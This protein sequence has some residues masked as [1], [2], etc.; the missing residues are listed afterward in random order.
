M[1]QAPLK[2]P[3]TYQWVVPII[4]QSVEKNPGIQYEALRGLIRPYAKEYAITPSL[5]QDAREAAKKVI[6][7]IA[8]DNV[9][10]A[11]GVLAAMRELGH[12]A[13]LVYTSRDETLAA[14]N[15]IVIYEEI[16]RRKIKNE[17]PFDGIADRMAFWKKWKEDNALW[18]IN[19]LGIKGGPAEN[20][21]LSGILVATSASKSIFDTTQEV[22]QADGAHTSFGKYTLFSAYSTT[23]NANMSSV[24][25]GI[26]FGNE[27]IKNWTL[28]WKFVARIHPTINRPVVTLL[29]D[30]DKGSITSV[31]KVIPLAHNFHCSYHRRQ[32]ILSKCGGG[33]SGTKPL[34]ALWLYNMLSNC[35]NLQQLETYANR[36]LHQLFP[37]DSHYLTKI[38][39]NKQYAAARCAMAP[40]IQMYGQSASSG[41][42]SMN[43]ANKPL[44]REKTAVDPLNAAILLLQLE[45]GRFNKWKKIAWA[46]D[47]PLTPKGMDLMKDAFNDVN[48][49]EYKL[50]MQQNSSSQTYNVL[51][52]KNTNGAREFL[53]ALPKVALKGSH[54]G[55]CTCG[56]PAKEG[57]PCKHMVVIVKSSVIAGLTRTG[58]MPHFWSA[59][60]WRDQYPLDVECNTDISMANVKLVAHRHG[61][62]RYCPDWTAGGK[63]GRPKKTDKVMT[64]MDHIKVA[65]NKKRKRT[66]K[67]FCKICEKWNHTT[68][69]CF[70]NPNNCKLNKTL[71]AVDEKWDDEDG[72]EGEA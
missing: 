40:D 49:R 57:V 32:N 28:F 29:T 11:E 7:G 60:H 30:Q 36:Y 8:E 21:F 26:L 25:F 38:A 1:S 59:A 69:Q 46:T 14:I 63:R 24:A 23:A 13:E 17:P 22:V 56:K 27:D 34:T 71:E 52:S 39:N 66:V 12:T 54:F 15:T 31:A 58:I 4:R 16:N 33:A 9:C 41:V 35:S 62:M 20:R 61:E 2:T 6:F 53:V 18:I 37:T 3:L 68:L 48:I 47:M 64:V 65:S 43:R 10:Y 45:G 19:T 44:V 51:V 42:E 50:N 55:S 70:K 5:L 72:D 67:M